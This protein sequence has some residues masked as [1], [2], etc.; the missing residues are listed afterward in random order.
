MREKRDN[1]LFNGGH[2]TLGIVA[3][4]IA[5]LLTTCDGL[6]TDYSRLR[7]QSAPVQQPERQTP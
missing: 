3:A 1:L 5:M 2:A 6:P 7:S 4:L